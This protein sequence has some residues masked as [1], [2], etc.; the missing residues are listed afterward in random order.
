MGF[1]NLG[2]SVTYHEDCFMDISVSGYRVVFF[3]YDQPPGPPS[4]DAHSASLVLLALAMLLFVGHH[5]HG[6]VCDDMK[7]RDED[8]ATCI[9]HQ[10]Y[11]M[12]AT[13]AAGITGAILRFVS[14][15]Q[16]RA[17]ARVKLH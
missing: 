3:K 15:M 6:V 7:K 8:V 14:K 10:D 5:L 16:K 9:I 11:L 2:S 12:K 1:D 17:E 13:F 4:I